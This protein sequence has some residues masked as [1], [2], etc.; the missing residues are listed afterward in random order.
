MEKSA[1]V[2]DYKYC[3]GCMTC[4]LACRNEKE[5]TGDEWGIKVLQVGPDK[6]GEDWLWNYIPTLSERCDL[7]E[8]RVDGGGVPSCVLHCLSQCIELVPYEALPQRLEELGKNVLVYT[9]D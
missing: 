9:R 4:Q 1:L 7:C 3:D 8:S 6:F 5:L 2:I